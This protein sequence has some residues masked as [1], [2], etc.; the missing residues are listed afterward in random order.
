MPESPMTKQSVI[1][2]SSGRMATEFG[3]SEEVIPI[4]SIAEMIYEDIFSS[5]KYQYP[6]FGGRYAFSFNQRCV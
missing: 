1:W 2:I 5:K 4:I 3:G 6:S